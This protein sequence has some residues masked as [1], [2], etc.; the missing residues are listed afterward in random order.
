MK[1]QLVILTCSILLISFT[2]T[3]GQSKIEL[4]GGIGFLDFANV[5]IKY[6]IN[7]NINIGVNVGF[8]DPIEG[9]TFKLL[10]MELCVYSHFGEKYSNSGQK[11]WYAKNGLTWFQPYPN[12][13]YLYYSPRVGRKFYL[14][15]NFGINIDAGIYFKL[16]TSLN[17]GML[18][19]DPPILPGLGVSFFVK[20]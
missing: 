2:W 10:S 6:S 4:S 3:Y 8:F 19:I 7:K 18:S 20:L 5:G 17:E 16:W 11:L 1:K 14:T 13:K 9:P 15:E 12:E